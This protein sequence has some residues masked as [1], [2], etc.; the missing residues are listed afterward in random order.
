M[1]NN[2]NNSSPKKERQQHQ[3]R[4]DEFDNNQDEFDELSQSQ[5]QA[6]IMSNA[7]TTCSSTQA[8]AATN[9]TGGG[10][11]AVPPINVTVTDS[12]SKELLKLSLNDR[13]AMEEEIHGVRCLSDLIKETPQLLKE[14]INDFDIELQQLILVKRRRRREKAAQKKSNSKLKNSKHK[15]TADTDDTDTY[16]D[17]VLRNIIPGITNNYNPMQSHQNNHQNSHNDDVVD[18]CY[19]NDPEVRLR[20]LRCDSFNVKKAVKRFVS[21]LEFS[22]GLF[23]NFIADRPPRITDF[24]MCS[25]SNSNTSTSN[26]SNTNSNNSNISNISNSKAN[27][28]ANK[29]GNNA[30]NNKARQQQVTHEIRALQNSRAQYLPFRDRA[31]RRIHCLVGKVGFDL[32]FILRCKIVMYLHWIA[33]EDIETQQKGIVVIAWPSDEKDNSNNSSSNSNNSGNSNATTSRSRDNDNDNDNDN[34]SSNTTSNSNNS[35]NN[36]NTKLWEKYLRPNI[37][38]RN[39]EIFKQNFNVA[40]PVRVTS[41]HFCSK[42]QPIYKVLS[43]LYYFSL[44]S[45]HQ[46]RY[47]THFGDT[48][49]ILYKLQSYGIPVDLLPITFSGTVKMNSH[50][51]WVTFRTTVEQQQDEKQQKQKQRIKVWKQRQIQMQMQIQIQQNNNMHNNNNIHKQQQ[52]Q[53]MLLQQQQQQNQNQNQY[54]QQFI[55][56]TCSNADVIDAATAAMIDE[57]INININ[58]D[59]DNDNGNDDSNNQNNSNASIFTT[60]SESS[61]EVILVECPR[62]YDICFRKGKSFKNNPGNL[63]F[64]SLIEET[65][66]SHFSMSER[67]D[68]FDMTL[69]I[70]DQIMNSGKSRCTGF[71]NIDTDIGIGTDTDIGGGQ[72]MRILEWNKK[73]NAWL[74]I[75]D[76]FAIRQK[77]ANSYKEYKRSCIGRQNALSLSLSNTLSNNN[78]NN[79]T[80]TNENTNANTNASNNNANALSLVEAANNTTTTN[81]AIA[82]AS[83]NGRKKNQRQFQQQ[84]QQQQQQQNEE[85]QEQQQQLYNGDQD[86][87]YMFL[88]SKRQKTQ[89]FLGGSTTTN[90]TDCFR[91][92]GGGSGDNGGSSNDDNNNGNSNDS[93]YYY[94]SV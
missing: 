1:M 61:D 11:I 44:N 12:L 13:N 45:Y 24:M 17:D 93:N 68:K 31:G 65:H 16:T 78:N 34:A 43:S 54:N 10:G 50:S 67:K 39:T 51:Q 64:R 29:K 21:F 55:G 86:Q 3:Q 90:F 71:D 23:G 73:R 91:L 37:K 69:K 85:Q 66:D 89:S 14:K 47:K 42:N 27:S 15:T 28:Y 30:N 46:S 9:G 20:F 40:L 82:S 7:T 70:A 84:Q 94:G 87:Q 49:E 81:R 32:D 59:N 38:K 36:S 52:Q 33:S 41:I 72:Q 77:V 5:S 6:T 92:G 25:N 18:L 74:L 48:I 58:N 22:Q 56:S 75:N 4:Y 83:G 88:Q 79:N 35:N 60:S 76:K 63:H 53:L 62:S 26:N 2:Y 8:T 57:G 80:S 19:V